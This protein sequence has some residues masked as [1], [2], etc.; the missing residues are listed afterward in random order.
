MKAPRKRSRPIKATPAMRQQFYQNAVS[1]AVTGAGI[2]SPV[3][4]EYKFHPKRR[5]KFDFA[6]PNL[7]LAIE[8]EG[9]VWTHGRH[10]RG[11]GYIADM[12]KYTMASMMDWRVIRLTPDQLIKGDLKKWMAVYMHPPILL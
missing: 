8:I 1:W 9:A 6:L 11:K 10:T 5:W 12:E 3:L 7:K 2:G 4:K